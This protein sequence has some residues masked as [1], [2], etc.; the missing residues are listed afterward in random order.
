MKAHKSKDV[1]L[2]MKRTLLADQR[3]LLAYIR[4]ALSVFVFAIFLIKF[5]PEAPTMFYVFLGTMAIGILILV[6][7][8]VEFLTFRRSV[9]R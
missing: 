9:E 1:R 6:V 4:T 7:G 3:T 8:F 2:D 5:F